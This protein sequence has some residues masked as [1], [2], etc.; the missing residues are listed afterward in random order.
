MNRKRLDAETVRDSVL[1][2]SGQLNPMMY[3]PPTKQFS[4]QPGVHVTPVAD[5][6]KADLDQSPARRRSLYNFIFRTRPDPMLEALDCPDA[7]QSAPVRSESLSAPQALVLW[8]NKF[9]LRHAENLAARVQTA[10]TEPRDQIQL[11]SQLLFHRSAM[12]TE[13]QRWGDYAHKHGLANLVRVL[14]NSSEFLFVE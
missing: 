9:M 11:L 3:G 10:T 12:A 8:N 2:A 7:S 1:L 4:V 6:D 14:F 5:Y 13:S